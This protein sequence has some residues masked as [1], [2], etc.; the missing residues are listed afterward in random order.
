MFLP[1][2]ESIQNAGGR[3]VTTGASR[4]GT[5]GWL[6]PMIEVPKYPLTHVAGTHGGRRSCCGAYA[7]APSE[8]DPGMP[9]LY[10]SFALLVSGI[11]RLGFPHRENSPLDPF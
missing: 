10:I 4:H 7:Y 8:H 9:S 2:N 1:T 3:R 5:P 6:R 11:A